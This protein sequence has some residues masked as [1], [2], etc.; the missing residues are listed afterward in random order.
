MGSIGA[1]FDL[2]IEFLYSVATAC[3]GQPVGRDNVWQAAPVQGQ[4][5]YTQNAIASLEQFEQRISEALP[6]LG[7]HGRKR[8]RKAYHSRADTIT[9]PSYIGRIEQKIKD[10]CESQLACLEE[11]FVSEPYSGGLVFSV[12]DPIDLVE[13]HRPGYVPCLVSGSFLLHGGQVHLNVFFR[14]MSVLE[15][16]VHDLLFLRRLQADFVDQIMSYPEDS[17][18]KRHQLPDLSPGLLNVHLSRAIIQ[19][20]LARSGNDYLHR[21]HVYQIWRREALTCID[22]HYHY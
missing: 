21:D 19:R 13:R 6:P 20:R 10:A 22:A 15:F 16:G 4:I 5:G 1:Q 14:S 18:P 12:F 9:K 17:F 3:H 8:A 11:R 2:D 7:E